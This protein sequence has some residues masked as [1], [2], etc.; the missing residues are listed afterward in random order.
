M[1][2]AASL[3]LSG[4]AMLRHISSGRLGDALAAAASPLARP[5]PRALPA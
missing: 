2:A 1:A 3:D 4:H 5:A